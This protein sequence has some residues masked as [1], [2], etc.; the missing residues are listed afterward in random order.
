MRKRP[1]YT[2][3]LAIFDVLL[4][5]SA[6]IYAVFFCGCATIPIRRA[7]DASL[8]A[9]CA[10]CNKAG[11]ACAVLKEDRVTLTPTDVACIIPPDSRLTKRAI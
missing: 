5:L 10:Q 11:F 7:N 6:F 2:Q 9:E 8:I 3:K 1:T 4:F